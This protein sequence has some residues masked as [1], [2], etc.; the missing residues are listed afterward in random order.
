MKKLIALALAIGLSGCAETAQLYP[1]NDAAHAMGPLKAD[2]RRTGTN[3]GPISI[4]LPDGE[5]LSG[6]YSVNEGGST[7]FGHLYTSVYGTGGNASASSFGSSFMIP[8]S[9]EGAADLI[10]ASGMTAHC[11]FVANLLSAHGNGAC[12]LSNGATYRV[13][14]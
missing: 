2:L 6:R 1:A 9:G 10:G 5:I 4:T 13:Q 3:S 8:N 7:N 14:F 12:Q 11:E